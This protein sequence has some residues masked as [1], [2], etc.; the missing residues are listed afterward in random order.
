M[1]TVNVMISRNLGGIEQAFLDYGNA[2][3]M[4][5]HQVFA[6]IDNGCKIQA[7]L[8]ALQPDKIIRIPFVHYNYLLICYLYFKLKSYAPDVIIVH[9][10]KAIPIFKAV[11]RMLNAKIIGVSHNPKYKQVNKCDGIFTITRYQKEIFSDKGFPR[12]NIFVVPNLISEQ[13]AFIPITEFHNPPVIGTMGRFDPM[14]GFPDFIDALAILKRK[15][16]PFQA[17]IGGAVQESYKK[18]Y[19]RIAAKVKLFGLEKDVKFLGWVQNKDEF[20][21]KIDVFVLPSRFEPFGIVLL[22]AMMRSKPIVSSEAEG[23][24]EIFAGNPECAYL[25]PTENPEKMAAQLEKSITNLSQ[26]R[27]VAKNGYEL[28]Q[29]NYTLNRVAEKL[30]QAL[31]YFAK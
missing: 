31:S 30:N 1:K 29:K 2:L 18:E 27:E 23:P 8:E 12:D 7:Q 13:R 9:N 4:Y 28:C 14:K 22:E 6:V 11:A 17:V 15:K 5:N 3:K 25:F 10:K 20:F 16:V 19:E 26:T 24:R 21:D